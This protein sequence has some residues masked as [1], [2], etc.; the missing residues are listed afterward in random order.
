MEERSDSGYSSLTLTLAP[1]LPPMLSL[2]T[3]ASPPH[4]CS[5]LPDRVARMRYEVV[6]ELT[7]AEYLARM[8]AGWRR[9]GF[10]LFR[11]ACSRCRMCQPVRVPVAAFR[12]DRSQKRAWAANA[13]EIGVV[14]GPPA[15][16]ADKL[17]LYDRFHAFQADDKGWSEHGPKDAADYADSFVENPFPTEEW[18]YYAGDRLVGVGYVDALPGALSA[19]YFFHDPAE[20]RRSL[21]TFNVLS[22]LRAAADRGVPHVY[23][24]YYV[25]GCRSLEYKGRFRPNEVLGAD[26]VWGPFLE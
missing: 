7:P 21:G 26:G 22:V 16:T 12:P 11:P 20:R 15:V 6:G 19:I 10:T 17:A 8:N 18:C 9:F 24:G 23:L 4:A 25:E 5:Y 3:Y 2:H 14:V 13:D 1:T